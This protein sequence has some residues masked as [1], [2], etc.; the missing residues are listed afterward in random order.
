[1]KSIKQIINR[2]AG[3]PAHKISHTDALSLS[4]M[5]HLFGGKPEEAVSEHAYW[6]FEDD[7]TLPNSDPN[8]D[9][10]FVHV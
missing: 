1:M 3:K 4:E 10:F 7:G 2:L 5:D 6:W 9:T 8:S